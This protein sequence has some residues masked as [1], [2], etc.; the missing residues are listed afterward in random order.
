MFKFPSFVLKSY[1][2]MSICQRVGVFAYDTVQF[3]WRAMKFHYK[4]YTIPEIEK[5][6]RGFGSLCDVN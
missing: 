6:D 3:T 4:F 5:K 1:I 2:N